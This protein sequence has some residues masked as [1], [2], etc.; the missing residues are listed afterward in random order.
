M[1]YIIL[2]SIICFVQKCIICLVYFNKFAYTSGV[3]TKKNIIWKY[4]YVNI[5]RYKILYV[6][7][8]KFIHNYMN[9]YTF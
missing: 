8:I 6:I 4:K 3:C 2:P 7:L 1:I 9:N 5:I